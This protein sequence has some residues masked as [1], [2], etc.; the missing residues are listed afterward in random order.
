[1]NQNQQFCDETIKWNSTYKV[2][3]YECTYTLNISLMTVKEHT[4]LLQKKIIHQDII[5][6]I[7]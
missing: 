7:N 6:H 1:M 4:K 3:S 5:K 2:N